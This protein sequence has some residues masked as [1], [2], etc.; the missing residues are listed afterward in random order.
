MPRSYHTPSYG[1]SFALN[2][3][4]PA[5]ECA[6]TR[7]IVPRICPRGPDPRAI[8]ETSSFASTATSSVTKR[9]SWA[10]NVRA[11]ARS[12]IAKLPPAVTAIGDPSRRGCDLGP[13]TAPA[14]CANAAPGSG[15][16][17]YGARRPPAR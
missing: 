3:R 7:D 6:A 13:V 1:P 10:Q 17:R 9:S 11:P 16:E 12:S 2:A 8:S 4:L 5:L 14:R 15:A